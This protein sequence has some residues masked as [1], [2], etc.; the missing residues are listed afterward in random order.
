MAE[1]KKYLK[2][3][4]I[5]KPTKDGKGSAS[6][7]QLRV[8]KDKVLC[9]LESVKQIP[10]QDEQGNQK[11][12]WTD[13]DSRVT[14]KLESVDIGNILALLNSGHGVKLFHQNDNGNTA[15]ELKEADKG[16]GYSYRLSSKKTDGKVNAV[17]HLISFGEAET[18]K[19]LLQSVLVKMYGW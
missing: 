7:I 2:E 5:Y 12:A 11:F 9:F 1:A 18:I 19:V 14:M 6:K 4:R 17:S 3:F 15:L 16:N 10:G 13:K 8:D